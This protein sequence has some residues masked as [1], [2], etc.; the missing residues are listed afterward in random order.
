[1]S[2]DLS[3]YKKKDSNLD[4][5]TISE[6]LTKHLGAESLDESG[7]HWFFV[8]KET[9]NYFD[10]D[11]N[12]PLTEPEE[13]EIID[14]FEDYKY[15]D[16]T[17]NL[18]YVRPDFFGVDAFQFVDK[19]ISDLDL[20]VVNPQ[21]TIDSDNPTKPQ[22]G[23][24]YQNWSELNKSYSK[25]FFN[26][27]DLLYLPLDISNYIYKYRKN[28]AS[29]WE[30]LGNNYYVSKL[31]VHARQADNKIVTTANLPLETAVVIPKAD[32]YLVTKKY[33]KW[34]K[35]VEEMGLV[36]YNTA[37]K[38]FGHLFED[39]KFPESKILR[40]DKVNAAQKLYNETPFEHMLHDHVF[41]VEIERIVN[42]RP[43]E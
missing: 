26:E 36:S 11:L 43:D 7:T 16:F 37:I 3:F 33:K 2:Y 12:D 42:Y 24:I 15:T 20:F 8:H 41:R 25:Q 32:Y 1:M 35:E 22:P 19:F 39:Y 14:S 29:L 21:S 31:Y 28:R 17:F 23:E 6:Y 30:E 18:N 13:I 40:L 5:K 4:S 38:S 34:F 9:E 27:Y 10:L